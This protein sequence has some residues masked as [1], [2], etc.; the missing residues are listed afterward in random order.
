LKFATTYVS[1]GMSSMSGWPT[2]TSCP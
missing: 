1:D 2:E